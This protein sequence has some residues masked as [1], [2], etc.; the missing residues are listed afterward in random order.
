MSCNH[1]INA[2]KAVPAQG[3]FQAVAVRAVDL[4]AAAPLWAVPA[5]GDRAVQ[6]ALPVAAA[7][8]D[9]GA[10]SAAHSSTDRSSAEGKT[11]HGLSRLQPPSNLKRTR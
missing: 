11:V 6:A 10:E 1:C 9:Q 5:Q 2:D 3:V 4:P 7:A 8:L